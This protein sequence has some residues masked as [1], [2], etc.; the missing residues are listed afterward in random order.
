MRI[1]SWLSGQKPHI[2]WSPRFKTWICGG[3]WR[4]AEGETPAAA[5]L[6]WLKKTGGAA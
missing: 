2:V 1:H 3:Q 4:D 6:S 5:Y